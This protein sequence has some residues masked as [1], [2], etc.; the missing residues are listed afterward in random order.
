MPNQDQ[1][2][3]VSD[4]MAVKAHAGQPLDQMSGNFLFDLD[5]DG[6]IAKGDN[7]VVR[8]DKLHTVP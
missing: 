8:A 6:I 4:L 2:V 7:K 1:I 5:H 3:N